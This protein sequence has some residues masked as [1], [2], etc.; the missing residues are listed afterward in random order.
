MNDKTTKRKK[1][2]YQLFDKKRETDIN[3]HKYIWRESI[4]SE[5]QL[6]ATFTSYSSII[7]VICQKERGNLHEVK[8][9]PN[10][11]KMFWSSKN[12]WWLKLFFVWIVTLMQQMQLPRRW[13]IISVIGYMPQN[14]F[15]T[16]SNEIDDTSRV[17][18][19]IGIVGIKR[20]K[21]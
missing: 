13:N 19:N 14:N 8:A 21:V 16:D 18:A 5:F 10:K 11:L 2:N 12:Y 17:I 4:I 9:K 6:Q 15:G 1:T 20:G 7:R 3:L